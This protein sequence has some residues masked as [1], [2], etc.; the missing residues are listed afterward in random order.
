MTAVVI[1]NDGTVDPFGLYWLRDSKFQLMAS[2]RD[3]LEEVDGMNGA[4]DFG[5]E[6]EPFEITL[7][8]INEGNLTQAQKITLRDT[9]VGYLN[10]L[11]EYGTLTWE[12]D[13]TRIVAVRLNGKPTPYDIPGRFKIS[14]PLLCQPL[15]TGD[16]EHT[17]SGS[18]TATN[19]G[20][21]ETGVKVTVVGPC[22]DPSVT[23]GSYTMT[24]TGTLTSSDTLIIDTGALTCTY[25]GV[26]A[27]TFNGVFPKLEVGDNT[28]NATGAVVTLTWYDCFL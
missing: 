7:E 14:V 11:R 8:L 1:K 27:L 2:T 26:N 3:G 24:Y 23:I 5:T 12:S 20:T 28:V 16:T 4:V 9:V 18:G 25:N 22:T 15:W 19:A 6:L 21:F 10:N 17:L 13:P